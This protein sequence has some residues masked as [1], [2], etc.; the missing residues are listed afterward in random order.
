ME[1]KILATLFD[2]K[3]IKFEI[4]SYKSK[5]IPSGN[6]LFI[7]LFIESMKDKEWTLLTII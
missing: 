4:F 7:E 1:V 6:I 2:T 5:E 3:E